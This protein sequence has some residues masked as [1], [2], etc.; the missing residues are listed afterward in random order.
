MSRGQNP[1]I[2]MIAMSLPSAGHALGLG[3]IHVDSALNEPLSAEIDIVGASPEELGGITASVANRETFLHFG[4]ERHNFLQSTT[5]KVSQD[6][7]GRPVLAIRSTE[8]FNEPM[9]DLV[10]D[11]RWHNGELIRQYTLLLD[12]AGFPSAARSAQALPTPSGQA[13]SAPLVSAPRPEEAARN[14]PVIPGRARRAATAQPADSVAEQPVSSLAAADRKT[15][16]VGAK[17]TLRGIAWR[18]GAR[19]RPDINRMML[20]IFRANPAAFHGNINRLHLGALLTIPS[21]DEVAAIPQTEANGA[22]RSQM[23][24]WLST[25]KGPSLASKTGT[26]ALASASAAPAAALPPR[27]AQPAAAAPVPAPIVSPASPAAAAPPA[28][29]GPKSVDDMSNI[30]LS[31]KIT[32][33]ENSLREVQAQLEAEHGKMLN[34]E[35][36][37]R[38]AEQ[39]RAAAP[40]PPAA[41]SARP[42]HGYLGMLL[43]GVAVLLGAVGAFVLR[44]RRTPPARPNIPLEPIS[45]PLL[46][47]APKHTYS[48]APVSVAPVRPVAAPPV[49]PVAARAGEDSLLELSQLE[50]SA[51]LSTELGIDT[52]DTADTTEIETRGVNVVRGRDDEAAVKM[53]EQLEAAWSIPAADS[54]QRFDETET[55]LAEAIEKSLADTARMRAT[56]ASAQDLVDTAETSRNQAIDDLSTDI[57]PGETVIME[58]DNTTRLPAATLAMHAEEIARAFDDPTVQQ[59]RPDPNHLD[60]NLLD[61]DQDAMPDS[62]HNHVVVKDRRATPIETLKKDLQREPDRADLRLRALEDYVAQAADG[63][64]YAQIIDELTQVRELLTEAEWNKANGLAKQSAEQKDDE[65]L[66]AA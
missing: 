30:E 3:E 20:A 40:A 55:T 27:T 13:L 44:A 35:S 51:D 37:A 45:E 36:Q 56:H 38:F 1:L 66:F 33:L 34:M 2:W 15:M 10:V 48:P 32:Q 47:P 31:D 21:S 54:Y 61:L 12:P 26:P 65:D 14:A 43:A 24:S 58:A 18:A 4:A 23:S 9:V 5:F 59:P 57:G 16:K 60:F 7:H 8:S 22:I 17:A 39:Q 63:R 25:W 42:G 62:L 28:A 41:A 49:A 6:A 46:A 11:L 53:R 64:E 50:P 52:P 29:A 19:S